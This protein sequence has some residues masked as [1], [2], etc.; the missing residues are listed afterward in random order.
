MNKDVNTYSNVLKGA[1]NGPIMDIPTRGGQAL[2]LPSPADPSSS[3]SFTEDSF[4]MD[5]LL[6]PDV[7]PNH[8]FESSLR[9][10]IVRLE[11][12]HTLFL[13]DKER[14]LILP[15]KSSCVLTQVIIGEA[16]KESLSNINAISPLAKN[17]N[18]SKMVWGL[19]PADTLSGEDKYYIFNKGSY[20]VGRKG[21]DIIIN[22]DKGV[23]RIHAE[24]F[25]DA[26]ISLNPLQNKSSNASSNVRIRDC[27]KYGTFINNNHGSKEKV[28]EFPNKEITIK[29]GD[30]V[31]FGT[32][33]ATYRFCYVPLTLF[34]YCPDPVQVN[35]SLQEKVLSIGAC[36]TNNL[37]QECTHVLVDH[38]MPVKYLIDAVV[39]E[40]P[41][42]LDSWLES[43]ADKSICT[44]FPCFNSNL[45]KLTV[46]GVSVEVADT[47]TR[48]NCLGGY[49]FLLEP[50]CKYKS[51]D[52]LQLLLEMGG[53]ETL[54]IERFC[55]SSQES[56]Y[57]V[58][59][60]VVWVIPR[61]SVDISESFNKLS[62]L[63]RVNEVDLIF[64]ALSGNMDP[65]ILISPSVI[66]SSSCSTD[67]TVVADSDVE[68][69]TA[70]SVHATAAVL[71]EESLK[72]PK[73]EEISINLAANKSE[74][75]SA[76]SFRDKSNTMTTGRDKNDESEHNSDIIF[77]QDLVIRSYNLPATISSTANNGLLNFKRFRK[78]N[79]RSG[80][81]FSSLI[82]FS[83]FPYKDS[84]YG[85]EEMAESV[86][87]EK[88]R[89]QME[90]IS[91]DLFNSEKG[92]RRGIAGSIHG[93]LT[94]GRG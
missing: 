60:R 25:V 33:N 65:S 49:I 32:G 11:E 64:A 57:G 69:E 3:S 61:G 68:A 74:D 75:T 28:H 22:K 6:Q 27:S 13:L 4:E 8:S 47:K 5:I 94:R 46:E 73:K 85:A 16:A 37:C 79:T 14:L 87:E 50:T 1:H 70:S 10:R 84:D 31:S 82:P 44:E 12:E 21:C 63:S 18:K 52:R 58:H 90:A 59:N 48:K 78:T 38:H 35:V 80:N 43:L 91:E 53:A 89:K 71:N 20:K 62:S 2:P 88:K 86:K 19:F 51:G 26:M 54:S 24:I 17:I 77:S 67:E 66:I 45:P 36:V 34:V 92:R 23:S 56:E 42:V 7:V 93:L 40:K 39:A 29:D 81:S 41:L 15:L 76:T 30:L 55:S 72:C 83:K 9:S